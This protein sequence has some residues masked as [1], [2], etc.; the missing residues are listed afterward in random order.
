VIR[1]DRPAVSA[2]QIDAVVADF[3]AAARADPELG[4]VFAAHV[5]DWSAHE[6]KI[7]RF[8]RGAL[9]GERSYD[10]NPMQVHLAAGAVRP[11]H[12]A[13]WLDLFDETLVRLLPEVEA[14]AWSR[15]AHRIGRGLRMGVKDRTGGM[16]RLADPP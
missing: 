6:A 2:P 7:V 16:P 1:A 14:V 5:D 15:L 4:P 12:F 13:R 11:E 9:R 3:Y 8:W 10:G